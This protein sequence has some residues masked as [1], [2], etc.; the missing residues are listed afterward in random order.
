MR[1]DVADHCLPGHPAQ[2]FTER[3]VIEK[4]STLVRL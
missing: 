2:S 1:R 3:D 4:L